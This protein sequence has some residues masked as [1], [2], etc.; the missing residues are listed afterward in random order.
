MVINMRK[1]KNNYSFLTSLLVISI[2][3]VISAFMIGFSYG[4]Y[5]TYRKLN[6][7]VSIKDIYRKE[8]MVND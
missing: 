4:Q 5:E 2:A 6:D 7:D 3:V 8:V 1:R